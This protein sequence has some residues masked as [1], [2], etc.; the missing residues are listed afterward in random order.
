MRPVTARPLTS[1]SPT[2][3]SPS[4]GVVAGRISLD[5]FVTL[6]SANAARIFG[7]Y[8][9]EGA[10]AVGSDAGIA[11]WDPG[12]R[13][14]IDDGAEALLTLAIVGTAAP[15]SLPSTPAVDRDLVALGCGN[16]GRPPVDHHGL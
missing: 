8:P 12:H 7:L 9:R 15:G 2:A 11:L 14:M 1:A 6:T 5:Q 3:G 10:I 16:T 13:R 4:E